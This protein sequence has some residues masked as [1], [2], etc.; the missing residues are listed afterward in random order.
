MPKHFHGTPAPFDGE[1]A[2]NPE[3]TNQIGLGGLPIIRPRCGEEADA[4]VNNYDVVAPVPDETLPVAVASPD[5]IPFSQALDGM[6]ESPSIA[7]AA[8]QMEAAR[9]SINKVFE[10]ELRPP[11]GDAFRHVRVTEASNPE[12][13]MEAWRVHA[14]GYYSVGFVNKDA[15]TKEGFM[16]SDIDKARGPYV[17]YFLAVNPEDDSERATM[18]KINLSEGGTY[19]DLPAYQLCKDKLSPMGIALLESMQ[20]QD[21]RLKEIGALA[22]T[23]NTSPIAVHEMF[24]DAIQEALG[25][26]EVWFFSIVSTTHKTLAKSFGEKNLRVIGEDVPLEDERVNEG[27][28]LKPTIV[29]PDDFI[30][31]MLTAYLEAK[32]APERIRL[33]RSLLFFTD[34]LDSRHMSEQVFTTRQT[35]LMEQSASA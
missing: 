19:K 16:A 14:E 9:N 18:R 22:R 13:V 11:R 35:M 5:N 1:P 27:I 25:K 30:D 33:K 12:L 32:T 24:R 26:N 23:P 29:R 7:D 21:V 15:I 2:F 4:A 17:D 34:G 10:E 3:L 31:N 20:N 8:V 28:A 6:D